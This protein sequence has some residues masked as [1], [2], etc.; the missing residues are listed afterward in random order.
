MPA[1]GEAVVVARHVGRGI[2]LS[3]GD[4]GTGIPADILDRIFE[5]FFTTKA[6]GKGTGL[7]L[8][9]CYGIVTS[10]GGSIQAESMPGKGTR[11]VM[12]L[13]AAA[14]QP[15]GRRPGSGNPTGTES[16]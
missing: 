12:I 15:H 6:A 5:P 9:V 10:W 8:S 14:A 2:E 4:N 16:L 11:I 3:V 1:G 7:G 13:P